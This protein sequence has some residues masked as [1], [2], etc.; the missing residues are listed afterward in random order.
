MDRGGRRRDLR[1]QGKYIQRLVKQRLGGVT[2]LLRVRDILDG[3]VA[4][5]ITPLKG[6]RDLF[7]LQIC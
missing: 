6:H 7:T 1:E 2:L 4:Q 3:Q 5:T